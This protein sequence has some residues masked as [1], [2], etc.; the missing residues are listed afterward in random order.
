MISDYFILA[1]KNLK[2]RKLR[3]WLT[4][5]GI[6][7]SVA[8]I[9]SLISL[10]FG[11]ENAIKEQFKLFGSDK[12]F[13]QPEG[14]FG[15]PGTGGAISLTE[16]DVEIIKKVSGVKEA[17]GW[18]S[19]SAKVEHNKEIIFAGVVGTDTKAIDLFIEAGAYKIDEGRFLKENDNGIMVGSQYKYNNIF[20]DSLSQGDKLKINN[21]EFEIKGILK[22]LG[23]PEDDSAIYMSIEKFRE[24]FNVSDRV[25]I[26][27]V[28][29][30]DGE[31][32]KEVSENV[33]RKLQKSRNVDEN[34]KDFSVTT[35]EEILAIFGT[36]LNII[37]LFLISIAA[38]SMVVGAI[39]ITNT[40][41]TSVL[42]RT[43]EIGIM[44][45]VGAKNYDILTIFL[46]ESGLLGLVGGII[47][48]ILGF[49]IAKT[50]EIF[51][52]KSLGTNL[53]QVSVPIYLIVGC[54]VF[55]FLTGAISGSLPAYHASKINVVDALRYE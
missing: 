35:P 53:L 4:M 12:F 54:L 28:Q 33:D 46:I 42:E 36:V 39:G 37:T 29:I 13:V 48:V 30:E 44:K 27:V 11:L 19:A 7:I 47:G 32:I 1:L 8:T 50:I 23:N 5:L 24:M 49:G 15:V 55:A 9:F 40:M 18:V 22:T 38:I 17:T 6:I 21:Q 16:K 26:I 3:S 31:N 34:N 43:K 10:S 52:I 14:Q 25:D 2:K 51:A 41:Y 45:A 20:K